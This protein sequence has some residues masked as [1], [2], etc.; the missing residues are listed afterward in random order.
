MDLRLT[1]IPI[2]RAE[3][4][5]R[6]PVNEVYEAFVNPEHTRKFWFT[7]STGRLEVGKRIRWEWEMYGA[8]TLI[9]VKILNPGKRI[10]LEWGVDENPTSV[11][12]NFSPRANDATLVSISNSGFSGNGDKMVADAMDSAAVY[13]QSK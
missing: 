7:K 13:D 1:N 6:K 10:L 11:E 2:A 12:W 9:D 5:I 8:S 4:L 3:M